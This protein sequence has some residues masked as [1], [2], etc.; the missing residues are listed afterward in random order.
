MLG[1]TLFEITHTHIPGVV[2]E[3]ASKDKTPFHP[4]RSHYNIS[5][6]KSM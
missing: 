1:G 6:G 3:M 2:L 5:F 4:V